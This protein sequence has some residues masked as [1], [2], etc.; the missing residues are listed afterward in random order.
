MYAKL[1]CAGC[2]LV[3]SRKCLT[4]KFGHC[5]AVYCH[6]GKDKDIWFFFYFY[7]FYFH[8]MGT[9]TNT[10][11]N[12]TKY[13]LI[14]VF[15]QN[16]TNIKYQFCFYDF[17]EPSSLIDCWLSCQNSRVSDGFLVKI[18]LCV[19][20]CVCVCVSSQNDSQGDGSCPC[21]PCT[22][23]LHPQTQPLDQD[24]EILFPRGHRVHRPSVQHQVGSGSFAAVS[25]CSGT[26]HG[27]VFSVPHMWGNLVLSTEWI[28][29]IEPFVSG[30]MKFNMDDL[31][32]HSTDL[33]TSD[34][35]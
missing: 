1:T 4:V 2:V 22:Q 10:F 5:W 34:W 27:A 16:P 35:H 21:H 25:W 14:I 32:F 3:F 23:W 12:Y 31:I 11:F 28:S 19:C 6:I 8:V 15:W 7:F 20:V 29:F 13:C 26:E 30:C 18:I 17:Q 9:L 24:A 33:T